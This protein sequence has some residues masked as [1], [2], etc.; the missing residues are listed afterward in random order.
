MSSSLYIRIN[1]NVHYDVTGL[2]PNGLTFRSSSAAQTSPKSGRSSGSCHSSPPH[3]L[4]SS[5]DIPEDDVK[6][7]QQVKKKIIVQK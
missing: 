2:Q 7:V 3:T 4:L 5:P 1:N 6:T